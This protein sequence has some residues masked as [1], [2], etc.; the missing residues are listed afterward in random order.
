[1]WC[2]FYARHD[3]LWPVMKIAYIDQQVGCGGVWCKHRQ[4]ASR[5]F[6]TFVNSS[7][8]IVLIISL[9]RVSDSMDFDVVGGVSGMDSHG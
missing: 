4:T 6:P 2:S 1:M 3:G 7:S 9:T 5:H 8:F